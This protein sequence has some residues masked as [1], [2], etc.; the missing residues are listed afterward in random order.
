MTTKMLMASVICLAIAGAAAV[1]PAADAKATKYA[2]APGKFELTWESLQQYECP[3]WFRDAKF[4]IWSTGACRV[5]AGRRRL[6]RAAMYEQGSKQYRYHVEH[7]GHPSKVGFKDICNLWKAENRDPDKLMQLYKGA[8]AKYFVALANHHCNF[9]MW[10]SKYQPWN[11]VNIGPK[12]DIIGAWAESARKQGLRFGVTVHGCA[13]LGLARVAHGSDKTGPLA[14]VPYDGAL[15]KAGVKGSGGRQSRHLKTGPPT[16]GRN[17][18]TIRVRT[19]ER[20][21]WERNDD[22]S[23]LV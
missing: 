20:I 10:N 22:G 6:V 17:R 11:S 4:G 21:E 3:E 15:T 19:W 5:P 1:A 9:D 8:G 14:G 7:D 2:I 23:R 18:G 16:S 12:K 13:V